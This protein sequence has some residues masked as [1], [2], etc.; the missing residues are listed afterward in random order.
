M[1]EGLKKEVIPISTDEQEAL[2]KER[3]EKLSQGTYLKPEDL[4]VGVKVRRPGSEIVYEID[5]VGDVSGQ[6]GAYYLRDLS[7][8]QEG[9]VNSLDKN[10]LIKAEEETK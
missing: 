4:K 8:K 2:A 3:E 5:H 1:E 10:P 9:I 6:A 7:G